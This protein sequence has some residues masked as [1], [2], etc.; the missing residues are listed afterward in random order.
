MNEKPFIC[1][2]AKIESAVRLVLNKGSNAGIRDGMRF[3][4]YEISEEEI[5]DPETGESLGRL[6]NVKGTGKII[7]TQ[8]T[9]SLLESDMFLTPPPKRIVRTSNNAPYGLFT[10]TNVYKETIEEINQD[11]Q[12]RLDFDSPTEGDYAKQIP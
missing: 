7:H 6:E 4:V 5:K 10:N 1:R 9:M 11:S 3:L 2:V 12:V 8:E